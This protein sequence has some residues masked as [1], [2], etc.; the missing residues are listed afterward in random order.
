[1]RRDAV[2]WDTLGMQDRPTARE[3]LATIADLLEREVLAAVAGPLQHQVR[4]AGNLARILER[5]V[6][7]GVAHEQREVELLC[8]VLGEA[9]DGRDA[10]ELSGA[11]VLRLNAGHDPELER[12]AWPAL[13]E[14]VRGKLAINKPGYD[15]YD[16]ST[17]L[18]T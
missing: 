13:V 10:L 6:E 4:V 16:P 14:I 2:L 3:L 7:L 17:E 18:E 9:P 11:L 12:R 1:M 8:R 15:D 5:E